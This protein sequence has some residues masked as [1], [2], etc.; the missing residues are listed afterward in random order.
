MTVATAKKQCVRKAKQPLRLWLFFAKQKSEAAKAKKSGELITAM[1]R[2]TKAVPACLCHTPKAFVST[3]QP[4]LVAA[5]G[6]WQSSIDPA[7]VQ[8]QG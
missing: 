8:S 4:S 1:S 6:Y 7:Q 3:L 5:C 2:C